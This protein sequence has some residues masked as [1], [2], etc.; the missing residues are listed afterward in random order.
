MNNEKVINVA[1]KIFHYYL[2]L[3]NSQVWRN[4]LTHDIKCSNYYENEPESHK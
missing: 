1:D 4:Y 3:F 2:L